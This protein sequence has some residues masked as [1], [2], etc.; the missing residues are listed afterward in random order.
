[1]RFEE[2]TRLMR[3]LWWDGLQVDYKVMDEIPG[4][5]ARGKIAL[6]VQEMPGAG[7]VPTSAAAG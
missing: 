6:Y 4:R 2:M 7:P 5:S 1:M 3:S